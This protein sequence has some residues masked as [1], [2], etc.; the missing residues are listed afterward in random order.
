MEVRIYRIPREKYV[1]VKKTLEGEDDSFRRVGY[2]LREG[3]YI[4]EDE[5]FYLYIRASEEFFKEHEGKLN[6]EPLTGEDYKRIKEKIEKEE[7]DKAVGIGAIF[8]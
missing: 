8:G 3:K 1:E 4:N 2:I 5:N 7:E 6:A